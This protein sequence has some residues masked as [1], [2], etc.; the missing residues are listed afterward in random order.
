MRA[1]LRDRLRN[2]LEPLGVCSHVLQLGDAQLE[3]HVA[4]GR[5]VAAQRG[6]DEGQRLARG[7]AAAAWNL[8]RSTFHYKPSLSTNLV[9]K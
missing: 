4:D 1:F 2:T 3:D 8:G 6:Q 9:F 7:R 5:V